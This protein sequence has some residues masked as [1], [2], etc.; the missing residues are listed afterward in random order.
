MRWGGT[1]SVTAQLGTYAAHT[2]TILTTTGGLGGTRFAGLTV[3]GA[4]YSGTM[5]LDY[6]T[7][8]GGVDLDVGGGTTLLNVP[9]NA[10]TITISGFG[11]DPTPAND[12]VTLSNGAV[13]TVIL[14]CLHERGL[15]LDNEIVLFATERSAGKVIDAHRH[16]AVPR[17]VELTQEVLV[18]RKGVLRVDFY[19]DDQ[20]YL[21]SRV[22]RGGDVIL[23]AHGGHGFE[24]LE[25]IQMIEVKQGPYSGEGEK[26]RFPS[27]AQE[28]IKILP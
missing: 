18:L 8:P 3:N 2:Y 15:D 11:F 19:R 26:T 13:G 12:T 16:V 6:T 10:T 14:Q 27:V 9:A 20:T 23:L 5:T 7:T 24:V 1:V 4:A 21:E 25:E 22:L 28:R 17:N